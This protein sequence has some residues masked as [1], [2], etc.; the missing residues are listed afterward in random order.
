VGR[1]VGGRYEILDVVGRG[2]EGE[3]LRATD[4]LG[5]RQVALKV[6]YGVR[7]K[8]EREEA[9]R[10]TCLL[11]SVRPQCGVAAVLEDFFDV[12]TYYLV[13]EW[14]EG[15]SLARL[16]ETQPDGL[17]VEVAVKYL[18]QAADAIDHLHSH[19]PPVLHLDV[20]PSNFVATRDGRLVLV[21]FG[22]AH[23]MNAAHRP[24]RATPGYTAPELASGAAPTRAADIFSLA[25]T[26][27]T[28]LSGKPPRPGA[29]DEWPAMPTARARAMREALAVA[30]ASDPER[31]PRSARALVAM[32][33]APPS[34][35]NIV[36]PTTCMVGRERELLGV[37]A[38]LRAGRLV[39]LAGPGGCG[40]TRLAI[41]VARDTQWRYPDGTWIVDLAALS[42]ESLVPQAAAAA[43]GLSERPGTSLLRS[44]G[45][46]LRDRQILVIVDNCEHLV[47]A[48]ASLAGALLRSTGEVRILATSREPLEVPG[49]SICRIGSLGVPEPGASHSEVL[50]SDSVR[51]LHS[52]VDDTGERQLLDEESA[53]LLVSICR[54][55]DGIPLALEMAAARLGEISLR[56]LNGPWCAHQG[57][58]RWRR[59]PSTPPILGGHPA[60]EL[61]GAV[62]AGAGGVS[63]AGRV[64]RGILGHRGAGRVFGRNRSD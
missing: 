46:R 64:R 16:L 10:A 6:R 54:Q 7:S 36:P 39:T 29:T 61:H 37:K 34:P 1:L 21:D 62:R 14:V 42:D 18:G 45:E 51:L 32:L 53:P 56:T 22:T 12:D 40:K 19:E 4:R 43:L 9:V 33:D 28:L 59:C 30:L 41:E 49:E 47:E 23:R 11:R 27:H 25:A 52:R 26:A 31:R 20:K 63:E 57:P 13:M 2:G 8:Y 50:A 55:L 58:G 44:L 38:R 17:D 15:R 5:D 35:T 3:V 48:A 24:H 60:I